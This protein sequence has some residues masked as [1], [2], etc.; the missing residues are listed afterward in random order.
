MEIDGKPVFKV[1]SAII[2]TDELMTVIFHAVG[3]I[4]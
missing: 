1:P 2:P 4:A 3:K